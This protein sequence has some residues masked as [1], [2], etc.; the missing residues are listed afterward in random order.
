MRQLWS[1]TWWVWGFYQR[2][3][4]QQSEG[5]FDNKHS[6]ARRHL[7]T[8]LFRWAVFGLRVPWTISMSEEKTLPSHGLATARLCF[9]KRIFRWEIVPEEPRERSEVRRTKTLGAPSAGL[10]S[11]AFCRPS[12]IARPRRDFTALGLSH[13]E[14]RPRTESG[15]LRVCG[16]Q[17]EGETLM[18]NSS[19]EVLTN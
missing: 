16:R 3:G 15:R 1:Q 6:A 19:P 7:H 18:T 8:A 12:T 13:E 9:P 14:G 17:R 5:N 2:L 11:R 10:E 4:R